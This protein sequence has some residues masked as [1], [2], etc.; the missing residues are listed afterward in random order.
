MEPVAPILAA[1]DLSERATQA[2]VRARLLAEALGAEVRAVH[3]MED[4]AADPAARGRHPELA[5]RLGEAAA[6]LEDRLAA[7]ARA[8]GCHCAVEVRCGRDYVEIIRAARELQ[9]GVVV[10]GAHG[11][12]HL[13]DW[14]LGTTAERVVSK[15]D[16]PVLV[17]KRAAEAPYR[18]VL[19]PVDFSRGSRE[20][21]RQAAALAPQAELTVLHVY[22]TWFE[23]VLR[24]GGASEREIGLAHE[25]EV[26]HF[27]GELRHLLADCALEGRARSVALPGYAPAVITEQIRAVDADLV[28]MGT[29]GASSLRHVL[30]GSVTEHVLREAGCDVLAVRTGSPQFEPP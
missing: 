26:R 3:V 25:E 21:L 14:F 29:R 15:G 18:R 10:L 17:V 20:A 27:T 22:Q 28:A 19:V 9:A 8:A 11:R 13:S 23:A 16:R 2:L 12:H 7:Q 4:A 24:R 5:R 30:L 1:S 6:I